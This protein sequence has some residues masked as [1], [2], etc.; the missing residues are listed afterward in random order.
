MVVL[1][2]RMLIVSSCTVRQGR[3]GIRAPASCAPQLSPQ[4]CLEP[5]SMWP[6]LH[7]TPAFFVVVGVPSRFCCRDLS[8]PLLVGNNNKAC[9]LSG[10]RVCQQPAAHACACRAPVLCQPCI[11][12]ALQLVA[13]DC[14]T[15]RLVPDGRSQQEARQRGGRPADQRQLAARRAAIIRDLKGRTKSQ[16]RGSGRSRRRRRRAHRGCAHL[17]WPPPLHQ[18]AGRDRRSLPSDSRH[19]YCRSIVQQRDANLSTP[20]SGPAQH[21]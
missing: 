5:F 21:D 20:T 13:V 8:S 6:F 10:E 19:N 7:R 15:Q 9:S 2:L 18:H 14:A 11:V 17:R 1:S 4:A 16:G 12:F 3:T